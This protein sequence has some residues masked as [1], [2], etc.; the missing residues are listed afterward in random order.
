MPVLLII[1]I[2]THY[3]SLFVLGLGIH[4]DGL[5]YDFRELGTVYSYR[6]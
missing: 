1:I 2:N 4:S 6:K 3:G 5:F